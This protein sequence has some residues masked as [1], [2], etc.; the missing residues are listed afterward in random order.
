ME[1]LIVQG[2]FRTTVIVTSLVDESVI[3]L[4][5]FEGLRLKSTKVFNVNKFY[6]RKPVDVCFSVFPELGKMLVWLSFNLSQI[7]VLDL[8][9]MQVPQILES[10]IET[11]QPLSKNS[12]LGYYFNWIS[13]GHKKEIVLMGNDGFVEPFYFRFPVFNGLSLKEQSMS[14]VADIFSADKIKAANIPESL[15]KE[16]LNRKF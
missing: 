13:S 11:K 4:L 1:G 5:T 2:L 6:E 10:P 3:Y 16:I 9:T 12:S 15:V 8:I 7:I 14:I